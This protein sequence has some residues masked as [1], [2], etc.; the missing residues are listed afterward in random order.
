MPILAL[1]L[2]TSSHL[3]PCIWNIVFRHRSRECDPSVYLHIYPFAT[4]QI[5]IPRFVSDHCSERMPGSPS[6]T[7]RA[8]DTDVFILLL[9]HAHLLS[10]SLFMDVGLSSNNTRRT[11][12]ISQLAKTIGVDICRALPGFHSF[13]GSDYTAAF[14]RKGKGRPY[15]VM[16]KSAKFTQAFGDLGRCDKVTIDTAVILKEIVCAMYGQ[17]KLRCVND[18]RLAMFGTLR[19]IRN[20]P[21]E[22]QSVRSIL[23]TTLQIGFT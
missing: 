7:I 19:N 20:S 5:R 2:L 3:L 6:I 17:T 18:A 1:P 12:N 22:A 8:S 13:T 15:D 4:P 21:W 9:Y 16:V 23:L 10:S 11:I 14:L